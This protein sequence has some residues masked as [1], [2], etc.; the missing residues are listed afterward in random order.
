MKRTIIENELYFNFTR[1]SGAGGQHVNK[2]STRVELRFNVSSSSGLSDSEKQ[3]IF[4]KLRNRINNDDEFIVTSQASRSQFKNKES[5]TERFFSLIESALKPQ[6]KRK[7]THP[8]RQSVVKRLE[9]K[10]QKSELKQL[11]RKPD[12]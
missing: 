9:R 4:H 11:R 7:P 10:H 3:L 1:S 5:A 2:V 8:S 12:L 6:K